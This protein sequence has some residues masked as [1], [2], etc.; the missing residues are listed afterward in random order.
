MGA[1]NS[2]YMLS[3]DFRIFYCPETFL[4][5]ACKE[6]NFNTL[7]FE[8]YKGD[9]ELILYAY[10]IDVSEINSLVKSILLG[11]I[12]YQ[13]SDKNL[14]W[15]KEFE[16]NLNKY[17]ELF[18]KEKYMFNY[19]ILK[20][21]LMGFSQG[22]ALDIAKKYFE[23]KRNDITVLDIKSVIK[24]IDEIIESKEYWITNKIYEY[25]SKEMDFLDKVFRSKIELGYNFDYRY[26]EAEYIEICN[27]SF[28]KENY[29]LNKSTTYPIKK[30]KNLE[31]Q[32]T[33]ILQSYEAVIV[34]MINSLINEKYRRFQN[35]QR[36]LTGLISDMKN[37]LSI[38]MS[39]WKN[40]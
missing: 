34:G 35:D 40:N 13:L 22:K 25:E 33:Y 18:N 20:I 5:G 3:F 27:N 1:I 30:S 32:S 36:F 31:E 2:K 11:K 23:Y 39:L 21:M 7:K 17:P 14:L 38:T 16:S 6:L 29:I 12:S 10:E 8:P 15:L 26:L 19:L 4:I 28:A 37:T 24:S 9:K